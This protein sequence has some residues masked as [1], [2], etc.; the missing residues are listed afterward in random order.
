MAKKISRLGHFR[1]TELVSWGKQLPR[2]NS[3]YYI[4]EGGA[5]LKRMD[6]HLKTKA[7]NRTLLFN[8]KVINDSELGKINQGRLKKES[9][10]HD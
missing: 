9:S 1:K 2:D 10:L 7:G 3:M 6:K 5:N 8:S 4:G